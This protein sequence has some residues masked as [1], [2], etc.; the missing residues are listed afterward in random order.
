MTFAER[1]LAPLGRKLVA[2]TGNPFEKQVVFSIGHLKL[3]FDCVCPAY[4]DIKAMGCPLHH[5]GPG[6]SWPITDAK[7]I[8]ATI[9][10]SISSWITKVSNVESHGFTCDF[11]LCQKSQK[12]SNII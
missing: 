10:W 8:I 3:Q 5:E 6:G 9:Q 12:D 11:F 7:K 2:K 4:P 1:I